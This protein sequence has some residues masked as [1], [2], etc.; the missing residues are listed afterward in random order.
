[1]CHYHNRTVEE[2]FWE[3][4][5]KLPGEDACWI[6]KAYTNRDGYGT[7]ASAPSVMVF[8]HR[9]SWE[10]TNGPIPDDMK[11]LHSCDNASCVRSK[12]LFLGTDQDN[13]NDMRTKGRENYV[14]NNRYGDVKP[15]IGELNGMA[16]LTW[17]IVGKIREDHARGNVSRRILATRYGV[18]LSAID[19]IIN[20]TTWTIQLQHPTLVEETK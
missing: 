16:K 18:S 12:H 7:F 6:W 15:L 11:V 13:M 20:N 9:F 19:N 14:P 10:L 4:V 17:E 5:E 1:M 2:R 3:K 8:A